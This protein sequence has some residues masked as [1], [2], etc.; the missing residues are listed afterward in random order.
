MPPPLKR[1]NRNLPRKKEHVKEKLLSCR[2]PTTIRLAS[3]TTKKR[4]NFNLTFVQ[5]HVVCSSFRNL[6]IMFMFCHLFTHQPSTNIILFIPLLSRSLP[7]TIA[8]SG[9]RD[10][11]R[12]YS[13]KKKRRKNDNTSKMVKFYL[14]TQQFLLD[15]TDC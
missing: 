7:K 9:M 10:S 6:F 1:E 2:L 13:A 3:P 5:F 15:I 8:I 12:P 14:S 11:T 4:Q